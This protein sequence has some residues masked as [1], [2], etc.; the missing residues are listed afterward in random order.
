[1]TLS[2]WFYWMV[3]AIVLALLELF[4]SRIFP[5]MFRFRGSSNLF[6][7]AFGSRIKYSARFFHCFH[8]L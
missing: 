3:G 4:S 8:Y 7:F 2:F 5:F 6:C 1:M